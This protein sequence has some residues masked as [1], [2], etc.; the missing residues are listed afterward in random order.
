MEFL[1]GCCNNLY[2]S[3]TN[4]INKTMEEQKPDN[5]MK[6]LWIPLLIFIGV[7]VAAFFLTTWVISLF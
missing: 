6:H 5:G 2:F 7:A 4:T 1:A 3:A